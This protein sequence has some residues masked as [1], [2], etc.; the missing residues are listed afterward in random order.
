[1]FRLEIVEEALSLVPKGKIAVIKSTVV[2]G[3]T[4]ALQKK[5]PDITILCSPEFLSEK[6]ARE[7]TDHP[8]NTI[9]GLGADTDIHRNA[10]AIILNILPKGVNEYVCKARE[11]EI[12][13]YLFN[14]FGYTKTV[15]LNVFY[16]LAMQM[17]A[18]WEIVQKMIEGDPMVANEKRNKAVHKGGRGAGG[19]CLL[20]DFVA[21][22]EIYAR[23]VADEEGVSLLNALEKKNLALLKSTNKDQDLVKKVYGTKSI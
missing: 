16:D 21:F 17:E 19:N 9:I 2:P 18:D 3:T 15:F 7:D 20:K 1:V 13:K 6:T 11:A 22:K 4:E 5:M 8:T 12:F 23:I 14:C 10:A